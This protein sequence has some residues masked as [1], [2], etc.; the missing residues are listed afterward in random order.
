MLDCTC[1]ENMV[2]SCQSIPTVNIDLIGAELLPAVWI[3]FAH[4]CD[5]FD[6][7]KVAL[8]GKLEKHEIQKRYSI[9]IHIF[10]S[11]DIAWRAALRLDI[12]P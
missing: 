12:C 1:F 10:F 4:L 11:G 7:P 5:S 6:F 8:L 3:T 9:M 2:K